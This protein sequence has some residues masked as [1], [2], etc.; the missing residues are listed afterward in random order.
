VDVLELLA[1]AG[2]GVSESTVIVLTIE[3]DAK[4]GATW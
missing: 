2:S 1:G 3:G 4:L